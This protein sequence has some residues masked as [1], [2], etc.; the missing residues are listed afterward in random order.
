M[1]EGRVMA[2]IGRGGHEKMHAGQAYEL[3]GP[4]LMSFADAVADIAYGTSRD[5]RYIPLNT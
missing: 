1:A 3:S 4:R 5:I 2:V